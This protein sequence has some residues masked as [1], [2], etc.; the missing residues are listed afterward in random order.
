MA[1]NPD[2]DTVTKRESGSRLGAS[3]GVAFGVIS[4]ILIWLIVM[5][6]LVWRFRQ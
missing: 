3:T 2:D 4:G 5:G 6:L 1:K